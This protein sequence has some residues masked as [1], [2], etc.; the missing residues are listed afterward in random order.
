M[1]SF[2]KIKRS[3]SAFFW[4]EREIMAHSNSAWIVKV[5]IALLFDCYFRIIMPGKGV[6]TII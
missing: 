5:F 4:E 6:E 3:D 1:L 2:L